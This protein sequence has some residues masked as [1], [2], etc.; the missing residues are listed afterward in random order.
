MKKYVVILILLSPVV[1]EL[2]SGSTPFFTFFSPFVFLIYAGFYGLGAVLIRETVVHKKLG[3]ASVLLLGA[4]FGVLEEGILLKS[5]FD[6]TW[7]G[8]QITSEA[9]RV[10]GISVL[11]P[12]ANVVYH[13]V[14][15][16]AAPIVLVESVTSRE[17]WLTKKEMVGGG[18]LFVVA[19]LLL[20]TFNDYRIEGWQYVL[21]IVLLVVFIWLGLKGITVSGT[22]VYSPGSI[23]G[24]C[25]VF[26]FL[27]FIIFYSLSK[28]GVP[29]FI[30]L[31]SALLLYYGFGRAFSRVVWEST[32]YF[33]AASGVITGLLP[34]VA[35]MART[36]LAKIGNLVVA[37]L[38]VIFLVVVYKR[39]AARFMR[40]SNRG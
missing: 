2:L 20:S 28:A 12:F 6:P 38:F 7:M 39:F 24:L 27:L 35:V 10:Y 19:A 16:I 5:W 4:A 23:W 25:S 17:P 21:G 3:Y 8:A 31:G 26:V 30:I 32:H 22:K 34:V 29:W 40:Y 33:A 37:V 9:L 15:S 1:A 18:T 36:D 13:A 14:V 11:Q